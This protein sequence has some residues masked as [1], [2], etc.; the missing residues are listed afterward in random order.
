MTDLLYS[1]MMLNERLEGF[2][3]GRFESKADARQV[4]E[5]Y[6]SSVPGF[7]DCPY[8]YEITE[9][10]VVGTA[11]PFGTVHMIWRWDEDTEGSEVDIWSSDCYTDYA[12]AQ[13]VLADAG[14]RLNRRGWSMDTYRVGQCHLTEGF[15]RIFDPE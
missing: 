3:I 8:T 15:V 12:D 6:L 1:L 10:T 5:Y 7:R 4:A 11:A 13:R 2:L 14:Q 9:K